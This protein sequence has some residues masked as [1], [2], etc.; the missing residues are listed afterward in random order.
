MHVAEAR[1]GCAQPRR[2]RHIYPVRE[3]PAGGPRRTPTRKGPLSLRKPV[4]R[5]CDAV[6][7]VTSSS[8]RNAE[9]ARCSSYPAYSLHQNLNS[10]RAYQKPPL[11]P[12]GD[13]TECLTP[14]NC[15]V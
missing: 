1:C 2:V 8:A 7:L 5:E 3:R 15:K 6:C 9:G 4:L 12:K 14:R 13:V 10:A 11:N